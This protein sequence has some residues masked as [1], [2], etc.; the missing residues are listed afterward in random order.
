MSHTYTYV[1]K[2]VEENCRTWAEKK[3]KVD[4]D[5]GKMIALYQIIA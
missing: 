4:N 2:I 1:S 3:S 5:R